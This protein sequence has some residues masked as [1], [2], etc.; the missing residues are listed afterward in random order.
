MY[1]PPSPG[2]FILIWMKRQLCIKA[3]SLGFLFNRKQKKAKRQGKAGKW[4]AGLILPVAMIFLYSIISFLSSQEALRILDKRIPDKNIEQEYLFLDRSIIRTLEEIEEKAQLG[5]IKSGE[6]SLQNTRE[7]ALYEK[8][9]A[10]VK[11][12]HKV[13]LQKSYESYY[14]LVKALMLHDL[15]HI[16]SLSKKNNI[17]DQSI[18]HYIEN[19]PESFNKRKSNRFRRQVIF[20]DYQKESFLKWVGIFYI[21]AFGSFIFLEG[22]GNKNPMMQAPEE[23]LEYL[24]HFPIPTKI[25]FLMP[26]LHRTFLNFFA[27]IVCIP[28]TMVSFRALKYSMGE[29]FIRALPVSLCFGLCLASLQICY[30]FLGRYN[31]NKWVRKICSYMQMPG[32]ALFCVL[33]LAPRLSMAFDFLEPLSEIN[34]GKYL[35]PNLLFSGIVEADMVSVLTSCAVALCFPIIAIS[36]ISAYS[37]GGLPT[38]PQDMVTSR[39]ATSKKNLLN[40]AGLRLIRDRNYL[41]ATLFSPIVLFIFYTIM[42]VDDGSELNSSAA[43]G[44]IFGACSFIMMSSLLNLAAFEGPNLWLLFSSPKHLTETLKTRIHFWIKVVLSIAI[45]IIGILYFYKPDDFMF[46]KV[47]AMLLGIPSL[48][49]IAVS[50]SFLAYPPNPTGNAVKPKAAYIYLF[51]FMASTYAQSALAGT[52]GAHFVVPVLFAILAMSMWLENKRNMPYYLDPDYKAPAELTLK[53]SMLWCLCFFG[54]QSLIFMFFVISNDG[55]APGLKETTISFGISAFIVTALSL[56]WYRNKNLYELS[57]ST[58]KP[59]SMLF[60]LLFVIVSSLVFAYIANEYTIYMVQNFPDLFPRKNLESK[61]WL[62]LLAVGFAPLFE[63]YLFRRLLLVSLLKHLKVSHA[64]L[65]GS[66]IFAIVHPL[67]SFPPVFCVGLAC[68]WIYWRSGKLW[69]AMLLHAIYNATVVYLY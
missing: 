22:I 58:N 66:L 65:T 14:E 6:L 7:E 54:L 27:Y 18:K 69:L 51:M 16:D 47:I 53:N 36:F 49:Y 48:C 11:I 62:F 35:P 38:E 8:K 41:I 20:N 57:K 55:A 43:L 1:K 45:C 44:M 26:L 12:W 60:S 68:A 33:L 63:E 50:L 25:L 67:T 10:L 4:R 28:A 61:V 34:L 59:L 46:S 23:D 17:I 21:L 56:N 40:P 29:A 31:T 3:N 37:K 9:E 39:K 52:P 24:A 64:L 42:I 5:Q 2:H 30:Q 13:K 32:Y 19:G 15:R